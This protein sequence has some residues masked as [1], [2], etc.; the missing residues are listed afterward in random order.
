MALSVDCGKVRPEEACNHVIE[1]DTEEELMR[2]VAEHAKT[3][4]LEPTP[5]LVAKVQ[6]HIQRT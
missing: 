1:A 2:K 5:E 4:N 3:H 6:Q